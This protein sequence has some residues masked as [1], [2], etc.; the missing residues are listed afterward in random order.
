MNTLKLGGYGFETLVI[1]LPTFP[2]KP[3]K[4]LM[5]VKVS[6][7]TTLYSNEKSPDTAAVKLRVSLRGQTKTSKQPTIVFDVAIVGIF[8]RIDKTKSFSVLVKQVAAPLLYELVL[9]H[10]A[11]I[12]SHAIITGFQ[13]P[14]KI[15]KIRTK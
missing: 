5:P 10:T 1:K 9:E 2:G 12:F 8:K 7:N 15:G 11:Q 4:H 6:F 13:L 3:G 14:P